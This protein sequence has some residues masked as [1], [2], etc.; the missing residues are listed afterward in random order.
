MT[1]LKKHTIL[2]I[3]LLSSVSNTIIAQQY[4]DP[5]KTVEPGKAPGMK[6]RLLSETKE[7]KTYILVFAKG[8]EVVSGLT[9]FARQYDIKSGH[10]QAIGDALHIEV[11]W[12]DYQKKAFQVIPIDTAEVTS[13]TGDVAWYNGNPV[14]HTHMT[15][16]LADGSMKGGHLLKL[17][18]GPT[19]ELIFTAEPTPLIKKKNEEFNAGL[20][21]LEAIK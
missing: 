11:G 12:F 19:L 3:L 6:V 15:A 5:T 2:A 17:I 13:F 10:Y 9:S 4:H 8:D 7:T 1:S 21:D 14:A 18:V 20:I 16:S